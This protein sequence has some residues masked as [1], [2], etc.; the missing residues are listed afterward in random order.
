[1]TYNNYNHDD[2]VAKHKSPNKIE[3]TIGDWVVGPN[4]SPR[5]VDYSVL[6]LHR[7]AKV[8]NLRH[9]KPK[10][11]EYCWFW[12]VDDTIPQLLQFSYYKPDNAYPYRSEF[13][14]FM[15]CEP[16]IGQLPS[17]FDE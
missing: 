15:Y 9:W 8:S 6:N 10:I 5:R 2:Y 12:D 7:K 14:Y 11:G 16:F 3:I 4:N 13:S 17:T 1:M